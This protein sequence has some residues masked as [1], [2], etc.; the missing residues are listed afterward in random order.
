M[1]WFLE[2]FLVSFS[3]LSL[4][5]SLKGESTQFFSILNNGVPSPCRG[6]DRERVIDGTA[7]TRI[8]VECISKTLLPSPQNS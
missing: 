8:N 4:S 5:L 1:N 3:T 2:C 6:R 7:I